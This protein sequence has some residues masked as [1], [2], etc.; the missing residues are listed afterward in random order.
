M[1]TEDPTTWYLVQLRWPRTLKLAFKLTVKHPKKS[2]LASW[3]RKWERKSRYDDDIQ[4]TRRQWVLK[5]PAQYYGHG[6]RFEKLKEAVRASKSKQIQK[7]V[8]AHGTIVEIV[9]VT[10][11]YSH[12]RKAAKRV[13]ERRFSEKLNAM[14][15]IAFEHELGE[16]AE[17]YP[18]PS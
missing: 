9:E 1:K 11:D 16:Y 18:R 13:V 3:D 17:T 4:R 15:V 8:D 14:E 12:R 2:G 5:T 6:Y 7:E 10:G